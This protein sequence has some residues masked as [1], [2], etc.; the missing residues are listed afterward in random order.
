M[1]VHSGRGRGRDRGRG[2]G[3]GRGRGRG[4]GA[5]PGEDPLLENDYLRF[6]EGSETYHIC[7][8]FRRME[9][10]GHCVVD[11][12]ALEEIAEAER[13]RKFIRDD[14]PC[15]RYTICYSYFFV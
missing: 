7:E 14:N 5:D 1:A 6:E 8:K 15:S 10:G 4:R 12:G 9:I 3:A 11:W 13:A 2:R